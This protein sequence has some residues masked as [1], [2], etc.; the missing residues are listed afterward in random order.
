MHLLLLLL[1]LLF[2]VLCCPGEST[3]ALGSHHPAAEEALSFH[4]LQISSFANH[5]W[6]LIQGP[7]WV[8]ELQT[9]SWDGIVGTICFLRSWSQGDCSKEELKNLQV[10]LQV[11]LCSFSRE[12]QA[13]ASQFQFEYDFIV[14]KI[15]I[16]GAYQGSDF[17]SFQGSS[18]VPSPAAGTRDQKV[19]KVIIQT[20]KAPESLTSDLGFPL[21]SISPHL[22][23][24]REDRGWV[25]TSPNPGPGHL[26]LVC[27]VSGFNPKPVWVRCMRGE[28][29]QLGTRHS[30]LLPNS[31]GT[32]FLQGTL[33]VAAGEAAGLSCWVKHSSLRGHDIIIHWGGYSILLILICLTVL[34]ILVMFA[35]VNSWFEKQW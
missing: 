35:I 25:S 33:D 2:R 29:E 8:G 24:S 1:L 11:Y 20:S 6:V 32:W 22:L 23:F 12:V 27:H 16:N 9:H 28:R 30:D 14:I 10:L 13:F 31:D 19:Y 15:F 17:L 5:S 7:G 3:A 21:N 4:M 18:W 26:L 34:I